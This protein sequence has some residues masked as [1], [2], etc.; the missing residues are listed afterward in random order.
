LYD[1]FFN[2]NPIYSKPPPELLPSELILPKLPSEL[3]ITISSNLL[4]SLNHA[5]E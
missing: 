1:S 4:E 3:N 5:P 2:N